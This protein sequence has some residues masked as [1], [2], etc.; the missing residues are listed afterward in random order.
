MTTNL[1]AAGLLTL[2]ICG[3]LEVIDWVSRYA[4]R[5]FELVAPPRAWRVWAWR[6]RRRWH[7]PGEVVELGYCDDVP[8]CFHGTYA[9][10]LDVFAGEQRDLTWVEVG[11]LRGDRCCVVPLWAVHPCWEPLG[12]TS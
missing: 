1:L 4:M 5:R 12:V 2:A 9:Y 8:A 3:A 10:V 6:I 7:A 11:E